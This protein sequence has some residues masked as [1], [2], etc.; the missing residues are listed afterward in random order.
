MVPLS[1]DEEEEDE[2]AG[3]RPIVEL[4]FIVQVS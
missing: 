4:S 2:E 3:T 1:S